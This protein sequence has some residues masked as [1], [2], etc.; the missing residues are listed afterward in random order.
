MSQF[1]LLFLLP[2]AVAFA[3]AMDLFTLTI[4]NRISLVMLAGFIPAAWYAGLD[5]WG[6]VDHVAAGAVVL[7]IGFG[8]FARGVFG[9]GDAK[10]LAAI[11]LWVGLENLLSYMFWVAMVGGLL[12]VAFTIGRQFP[13]PR[14]FL[15]QPWAHRLHKQGGGIPYGVALAFA[16]LLVY[17][18]TVWFHA[19]AP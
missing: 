14:Q 5:L 13:L 15:G 19:M 16:A 12:A 3:A 7:V 6:I 11:S 1:W 8:L 17:P 9:G 18:Q 4:P 2:A 10:L